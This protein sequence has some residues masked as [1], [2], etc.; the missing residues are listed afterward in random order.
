MFKSW[1]LPLPSCEQTT[2]SLQT[3]VFFANKEIKKNKEILVE[4][5]KK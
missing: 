3:L 1:F 2:Y 4:K 5:K